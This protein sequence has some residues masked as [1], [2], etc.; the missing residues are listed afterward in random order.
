MDK[1]IL[2]KL[3]LEEIQKK[4][5]EYAMKGALKSMEDFYTGYDSPYKKA[6]KEKLD[7]H[8][9]GNIE[10]P[11]IIGILNDG[12][13]REIDA[14]ANSA[15]AKSFIPLVKRFLVRENTEMTFS[16]FLKKFIKEVDAEN[17]EQC[18]LHVDIDKQHGWICVAISH[19]TKYDKTRKYNLTFHEDWKTKNEP[20]RKYKLLSL[21]YNETKYI[22][23]VKV[24]VDGGSIEVPMTSDV[25]HDDFM[26]F[27]AR[28]VMCE[29]SFTMDCDE[30]TEDMF[31]EHGCHC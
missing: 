9:L 28:L 7:K 1:V 4:A 16:E 6:I 26:S 21:P 11:D 8:E 17:I 22:P 10:I 29:T 18:D 2:P 27:V 12:L 13:S 30:F 31:P 23:T 5:D 19:T 15:I 3:D 24:S 14:I 25:L 20:V